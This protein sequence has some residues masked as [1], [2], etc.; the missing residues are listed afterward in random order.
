MQ[1]A[2]SDV[3]KWS[4]NNKLQLNEDKCKEMIVDFKKVKHQLKTI[5]INSKELELVSSAKILASDQFSSI[6][7]LYST[8]H[9]LHIYVTILN[10][11]KSE[12]F[13]LYLLGHLIRT[14]LTRI[15]LVLLKTANIAN[16]PSWQH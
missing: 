1:S 15:I 8:T 10:A 4:K 11:F 2:V 16:I 14:I 3:E 12:R 6:V 7:H 13:Q 9:Y 5:I